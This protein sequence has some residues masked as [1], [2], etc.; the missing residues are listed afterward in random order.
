MKSLAIVILSLVFLL[1]AFDSVQIEERLNTFEEQ[2]EE[3]A[4]VEELAEDGA[5]HLTS[6]LADEDIDYHQ[7]KEAA[8]T[9]EH[10]YEAS[11]GAFSE[12]WGLYLS[13]HSYEEGIDP[14]LAFELLRIE[15]GDKFDPDLVGPETVHG[16]AYGLGQFMKNTG[17]WIADK[18]GLPYEDDFLF[19]PYYS[20]KL[21]V[22]YLDYLYEEFGNWDEALTA[23]HR[24]VGGMEQY[25]QE[26]GTARSWYA[27][28]IQENAKEQQELLSNN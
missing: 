17:P 24:G 26:N 21:T 3:L 6:G 9:A 5:D 15:T 18:A 27:E 10:L 12:E 23:Y 25:V 19:D 1:T 11:E 2:Q 22:T 7:L 8:Q 28:D 20:M 4:A 14:Y 13:Y 16:H